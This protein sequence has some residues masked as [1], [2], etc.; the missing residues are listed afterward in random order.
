[1]ETT[2][3][4]GKRKQFSNRLLPM[5]KLDFYRLFHT[6]IFY[7]M[8]CVAALIPVLVLTMVGAE[9]AAAAQTFNNTWQVIE[10]QRG[11]TAGLMDFTNMANINMVYIFAALMLSVFVAHDYSSG[12]VKNIFTVHAKKSDYVVSKSL[13][14]MFG[15]A[16]MILSY[17]FVTIIVGAVMGKSFDLGAANAGSVILCL[18]SKMALMGFFVPLYLSV[19]VLF[20]QKLW[21]TI[22]ATFAAGI[23]FYPVAS[24]AVPLDAGVLTLIS[25]ILAA[26]IGFLGFGSLSSWILNKRDLA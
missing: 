25:C 17:F 7:T 10:G 15:G 22:V 19:A 9:Q 8:V 6:P 20:K 12:F 18:L 16:C 5:I 14:G 24:L 1:M 4:I 23:L 3:T 11:S 21:I 13:A 2:A 26:G